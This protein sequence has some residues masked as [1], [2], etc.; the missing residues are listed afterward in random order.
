[1]HGWGQS[2]QA[3]KSQ[4]EATEKTQKDAEKEKRNKIRIDLGGT[5]LRAGIVMVPDIKTGG[6]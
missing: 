1:M 6:A 4:E 5:S 2:D 3:G